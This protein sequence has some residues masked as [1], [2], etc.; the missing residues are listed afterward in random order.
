MVLG[1]VGVAAI[2]QL[3]FTQHPWSKFIAGPQEVRNISGT[4]TWQFPWDSEPLL[5]RALRRIFTLMS[6]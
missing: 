1:P 4:Q 6:I 5:Q 3:R 2:L